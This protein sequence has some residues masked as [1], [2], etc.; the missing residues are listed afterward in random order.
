M[1]ETTDLHLMTADWGEGTSVAS[2]AG[3]GGGNGG[4]AT[5]NDATWIHGFFPGTMWTTAGGDFTPT[6]SATTTVGVAGASY[7]FTSSQMATEVQG[8]LNNPATNFGWLIKLNN[9]SGFTTAK[10]IASRENSDAALRPYLVVTYTC[11]LYTS[12]SPRDLSTSR[13]PSSA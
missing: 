12:P 4:P 7:S 11:L 9:E 10:R 1:N 3:G 5:T 13:M 8:W 2:G 6:P